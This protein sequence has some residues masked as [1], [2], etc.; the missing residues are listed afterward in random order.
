[1]KRI[2]IMIM[3]LLVTSLSYAKDID[4]TTGI[5]QDEFNEFIKEIGTALLFNPMAPAETL[6][7][8]GFDVSVEA[9][10]TDISDQEGYW[11]KFL[12]GE[13]A[14]AY[15]GVPRI[16]I[17]KGL[18]FNIDIGAMYVS[19]PDSNI[20]LWGVELKYGILEGGPIMPAIT[21]RVSYSSLQGVD[22]LTLDTQSLDILISK[23][24]LI[25][26]PYAGISVTRMNGSEQ[27]PE[28]IL[29]DI[30][31]TGYRVLAGLQISP[32]PLLIINGEIS[33]GE[34]PQYGLKLGFRF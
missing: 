17:Q 1:M 22:E 2:L 29:N 19:V 16:H 13:S 4:L 27:T 26:T 5:I 14:S 24:F 32:F 23:G 12:G 9:V 25:L 34:I 33:F 20:Q 11:H 7:I 10:V 3:A 28:V 31:E 8:T 18:P 30:Q 15:V 6:G 21:A